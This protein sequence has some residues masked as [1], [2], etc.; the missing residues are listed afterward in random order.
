[1][2]GAAEFDRVRTS[3]VPK[4]FKCSDSGQK[5]PPLKRKG[6]LVSPYCPRLS[7]RRT[8]GS[9]FA[10]GVVLVLMVERQHW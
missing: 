1:M 8:H 9:N 5:Q 6:L 3:R 7:A 2:E 10:I 4:P